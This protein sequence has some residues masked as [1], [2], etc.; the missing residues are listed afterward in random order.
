[1]YSEIVYQQI[2]NIGTH[3]LPLSAKYAMIQKKE[4]AATSTIKKLFPMAFTQKSDLAT[5]IVDVIMHLIIGFVFYMFGDLVITLGVFG[6]ILRIFCFA[7]DL[8]ILISLVL[9]ILNYKQVIK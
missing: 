3:S 6:S 5:I 9:S 1:M 8:Y 2:V 7:G 4:V